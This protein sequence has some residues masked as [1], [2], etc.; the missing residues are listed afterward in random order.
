MTMLKADL[1][2]QNRAE[3]STAHGRPSSKQESLRDPGIDEIFQNINCAT[4]RQCN[5][6]ASV[7]N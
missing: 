7:V 2:R 4:N 5:A 3:G 1:D 6:Q